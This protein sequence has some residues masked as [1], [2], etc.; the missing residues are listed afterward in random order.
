M[1][2]EAILPEVYTFVDFVQHEYYKAERKGEHSYSTHLAGGIPKEHPMPYNVYIPIREY[3]KKNPEEIDE[4]LDFLTEEFN[5]KKYPF[6][7]VS[8]NKSTHIEKKG[9]FKKKYPQINV[10]LEW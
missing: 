2:L 1:K 3:L 4:L 6:T 5:S 7:S 9:L 8:V 10:T